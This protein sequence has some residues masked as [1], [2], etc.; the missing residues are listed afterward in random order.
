MTAHTLPFHN[1]VERRWRQCVLHREAAD[2][3]PSD[4]PSSW[5]LR[6]SVAKSLR[7]AYLLDI[8]KPQQPFSRC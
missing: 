1:E 6:V 3:S 4:R 8:T 2:M 7:T 5:I